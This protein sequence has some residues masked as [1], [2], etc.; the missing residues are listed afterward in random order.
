[1]LSLFNE[2]NYRDLHCDRSKSKSK[3]E[4]SNT[5][6]FLNKKINELKEEIQFKDT[7]INDLSAKLSESEALSA[8]KD[9]Q[10]GELEE[11]IKALSDTEAEINYFAELIDWRVQW[12]AM[13]TKIR[14]YET[15]LK[16]E[17]Q[18]IT[19]LETEVDKLRIINKKLESEKITNQSDYEMLTIEVEDFTKDIEKLQNANLSLENIIRQKELKWEEL[20]FKL[21]NLIQL[22]SNKLD[23]TTFISNEI[24]SKDEKEFKTNVTSPIL[25]SINKL[26]FAVWEILN[27]KQ[28]QNNNSSS[29]NFSQ[30]YSLAYEIFKGNK[31][32]NIF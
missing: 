19:E 8:A 21:N 27:D 7:E 14:H 2:F 4:L 13:K 23:S 22:D 25:T 32:L 28:K 31:P 16:N 1:M 5:N 20:E 30:T 15:K 17:N 10:L 12:C 26:T 9:N 18:I 3:D 24:R 6:W 11:N 29:T